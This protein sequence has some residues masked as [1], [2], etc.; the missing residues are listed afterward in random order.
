MSLR[1][2]LYD[3][4]RD[5]L[6]KMQLQGLPAGNRTGLVSRGRERII[7]IIELYTSLMYLKIIAKNKNKI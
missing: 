1:Y 4:N 6:R 5:Q 2:T 7:S 3:P